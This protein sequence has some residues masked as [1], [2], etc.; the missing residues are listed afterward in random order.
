MVMALAPRIFTRW[1]FLATKAMMRTCFLRIVR[2]FARTL[3]SAFSGVLFKT[4]RACLRQER[5][6]SLSKYASNQ[7]LA[8]GTRPCKSRSASRLS[9]VG[10]AANG[11]QGLDK[12][13]L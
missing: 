11:G 12:L 7:S 10:A 4:M 9:W 13:L 2:K 6:S 1:R 5:P 3:N 8:L